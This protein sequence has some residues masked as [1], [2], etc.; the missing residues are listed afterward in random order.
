MSFNLK[1]YENL[2]GLRKQTKKG[3]GFKVAACIYYVNK[4]PLESDY[5]AKYS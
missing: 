2:F 4:S 1:M 3:I 5:F